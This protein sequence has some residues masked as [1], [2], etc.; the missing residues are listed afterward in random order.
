MGCGIL[1]GILTVRPDASFSKSFVKEDVELCAHLLQ[2]FFSKPIVNI[3]VL[4]MVTCLANV[5][6]WEVNK[7]ELIVW[8]YVTS[9]SQQKVLGRTV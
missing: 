6:S 8:V 5:R 4:S 7:M 9:L 1:T 3:S 2:L